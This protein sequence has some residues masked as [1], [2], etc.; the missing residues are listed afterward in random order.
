ME[1]KFNP[2]QTAPVIQNHN[3]GKKQ[4]I[5]KNN[6][7]QFALEFQQQISQNSKKFS[8][9]KHAQMRM[10]QRSIDIQPEMWKKVEEKM[11]EAKKMGVEDSLVLLDNAVLI[12]SNKNNVVVTAMN[13][14][15]ANQQ[16]FTNING[17]ILLD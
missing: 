4:Q 11:S 13:R 10:E 5:P 17:T 12:V 7:S 15:E 3:F 14:N 9:S 16:I 1:T 2:F 6:K 8:I